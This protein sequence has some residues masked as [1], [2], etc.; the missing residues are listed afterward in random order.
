MI[1]TISATRKQEQGAI[2]K[3]KKIVDSLDGD[4][5][6]AVAMDGLMDGVLELAEQDRLLELAE[7]HIEEDTRDEVEVLTD[8]LRIVGEM[9]KIREECEALKREISMAYAEKY[10]CF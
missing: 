9:M 2:R 7:R 4:S 10:S 8:S 3:I 1:H 6:V 5:Y